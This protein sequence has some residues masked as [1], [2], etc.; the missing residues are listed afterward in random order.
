MK[1]WALPVGF[2]LIALGAV[3]YYQQRQTAGRAGFPAPDFALR[4]LQGRTHR[5]AELRGKVVFLNVWATWCPP[6]R[7]EMPSMEQLHRR[8]Q[9]TDFVMLAVSEDEDGAAVVQRFIDQLG[10]TFP[11][12]LDPEGIVPGR[13]GV[14]GY[15]E[16]FVID[17][18]GRVI[19][20]TIGPEDWNSEPSYRY[21]TRVLEAGSGDAQ[22]AG[23]TA[24][25]GG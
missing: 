21:F 2:L 20:H 4:D 12:L 23:E 25:T 9:G 8:L 13:Y 10:L 19:Q 3:F 6:C 15:P 24:S 1:R 17:R 14:S 7:L 11:V 16:T 22:A 5:L 18:D